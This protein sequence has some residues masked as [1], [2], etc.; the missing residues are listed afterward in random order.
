MRAAVEATGVI[1]QVGGARLVSEIDLTVADGELLVV[2]GPNG[3]GKSILMRLLAG[4]LRPVS[5][6][7]QLRGKDVA[8]M[9]LETLAHLRSYLPA[10]SNTQGGF[11]V[12]E[13]VGM[14]R[15][16]WSRY[17]SGADQAVSEAMVAVDV[18]NLANRRATSL[19][20][21]EQR[22][23]HLARIL[24]QEAPIMLLDEPTASLDVGH[25]HRVLSLIR[26][27]VVAGGAAVLVAHDLNSTVGVADSVA[28]M[29]HGCMVAIGPPESTLTPE[30]LSDVYQHRMNTMPHPTDGRPLLLPER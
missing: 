25:Q 10:Q 21:G 24:A 5:G 4:D 2:I 26:E 29:N 28:V 20:T 7:V 17:P 13:V 30:L 14:G 16:P 8:D 6:R 1:Y 22:R 11:T 12:R 19:S 3:A 23:V 27:K 15:H 9:D 18:E